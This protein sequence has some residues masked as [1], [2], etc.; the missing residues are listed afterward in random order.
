MAWTELTSVNQLE[1]IKNESQ[2]APVLIFKH[3]TT[4]SISAMALNRMQ[5]NSKHD[6]PDLKIYY[7]DLRAHRDVSNT[8]ASMFNVEHESPQVLLID[9]GQAVYDRSHGDIDAGAIREF[10]DSVTS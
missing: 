3:S 2:I 10:L 5:R 4:C 9:K 7:L 1:D 6:I 8:I